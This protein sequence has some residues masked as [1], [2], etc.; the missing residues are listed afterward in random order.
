M[1]SRNSRS[2]GLHAVGF[3]LCG[4][5]APTAWA[6]QTTPKDYVSVPV[7][8]VERA[9]TAPDTVPLPW[10][11]VN[12]C[13][14][15]PRPGCLVVERVV[16]GAI[17]A[18]FEEFTV[19]EGTLKPSGL[20]Y[21]VEITGSGTTYPLFTIED[22]GETYWVHALLVGH[23]S[24]AAVIRFL[25][26]RGFVSEAAA[27]FWEIVLDETAGVY[28]E[29]TRVE[30][31]TPLSLIGL[32]DIGRVLPGGSLRAVRVDGELVRFPY[33][34][35]RN[36]NFPPGTYNIVAEATWQPQKGSSV[37]LGPI[38]EGR[39]MSLPRRTHLQI[40]SKD[41]VSV[42]LRPIGLPAS[43]WRKRDILFAADPKPSAQSVDDRAIR[44]V[45]DGSADLSLLPVIV[46]EK[47]TFPVLTCIT[48]GKEE[49]RS[50]N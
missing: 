36:L 11:G 29:T 30:T 15:P 20:S 9:V 7:L 37:C 47:A 8:T 26:L 43:L 3:V 13:S 23:R 6:A 42:T 46:H 1:F 34:G 19:R 38:Y 49:P 41:T 18:R 28:R 25:K 40:V 22:A 2:S 48:F 32:R 31:K 45:F 4:L 44:L 12:A 17:T 27:L 24:G 39:K 14:T 21:T 35:I 50:A 16:A 5:S 10:S 33:E